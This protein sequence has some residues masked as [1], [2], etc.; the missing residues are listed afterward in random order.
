MRSD[1]DIRCAVEAELS[2]HP[3]VDDTDIVVNV[4]DGVV[5]LSGY[6]RNLFHKYGAEDAVKR[7]AGVTAVANT[8]D[9]YRGLR[10]NLTDPEIARNVVAALKGALPD[11]SERLRPLVRQQTITLEGTVNF[12]YQR[13]VAEDAV[14]RLKDVVCVINAIT[15]AH[16]VC[17]VEAREIKQ[18]IEESLRSSANLDASAISVEARGADVTVRGRVRT[19]PEHREAE[20][21]AWS[22]ADV[23]QVHNELIVRF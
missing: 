9:L 2:C 4:K 5:T 14:R 23:H 19:R 13:Q 6:A 18:R 17:G 7:V 16:P 21:R 22:A 8:I 12:P 11:C 10:L 3:L 15:V 20:E 1:S